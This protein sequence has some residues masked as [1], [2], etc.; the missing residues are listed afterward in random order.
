M[1]AYV[2][3]DS[4]TGYVYNWRLYTGKL[5]LFAILHYAMCIVYCNLQERMSHCSWVMA[6]A[7]PIL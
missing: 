7:M 2:L 1:K 5:I 4:K 3:A 6:A